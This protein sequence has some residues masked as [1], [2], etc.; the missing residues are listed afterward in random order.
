[1]RVRRDVEVPR[2]ERFGAESKVEKG[3]WHAYFLSCA[4]LGP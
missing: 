1:M 4:E 3:A 2:R